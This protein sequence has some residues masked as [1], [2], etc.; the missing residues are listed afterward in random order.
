VAGKATT[1][2]A[3]FAPAAPVASTSNGD[4]DVTEEAAAVLLEIIA[5]SGGTVR[6]AQLGLKAFKHVK[7]MPN[8]KEILDMLKDDTFLSSGEELGWAFDPEAQAVTV[9]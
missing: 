4:S 6:K 5:E 3:K 9:L 1:S 8:K 7:D 2:P